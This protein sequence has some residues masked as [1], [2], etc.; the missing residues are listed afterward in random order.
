MKFCLRKRFA[1]PFWLGAFMGFCLFPVP[2]AEAIIAGG[3]WDIRMDVPGVV[4][5]DYHIEGRII[6]GLPGEGW[7]QPPVLVMHIDDLFPDF[8]YWIFPDLSDPAENVYFFRAYWSG[9]NYP[10][11]SETHLGL[12]FNLECHNLMIDIT[13]WWTVDGQPIGLTLLP[14]FEMNDNFG[15]QA[16]QY[17]RLWNQSGVEGEVVG[18]WFARLTPPEVVEL[19]GTPGKMFP[20]M[21]KGG[22]LDPEVQESGISWS[23]GVGVEP[24][25][26]LFPITPDDSQFFH[27]D[28]F[29][30][31]FTEL[32]V[33]P[34]PGT[35]GMD[36]GIDLKPAEF[37]VG[38]ELMRTIDQSGGEAFHWSW[39]IH[40]AHGLDFGDAPDPSYPTL[41]ASDG[42][43]HMAQGVLLGR[44]RDPEPDGQPTAFADGDDFL[45]GNDDEDGVTFSTSFVQGQPFAFRIDVVGSGYLSAWADWNADG[46]W[47]ATEQF[48]PGGWVT[49]GPVFGTM[50]VPPDAALGPTFMRYRISSAT[51]LRPEGF[52]PDGEV[53][54]YRIWV[55][56]DLADEYDWGDA[57]DDAAHFY[58]TLDANSGAHHLYN[59]DY[60][61]GN[62]ID[63]EKDG[64]PN[65]PA[66]GD[67]TTGPAADDEDG[68]VFGSAL[69]QGQTAK[70]DVTASNFGYV[71]AWLDYN[72]NGT[73]GDPWEHVFV[74]EPVGPG[75]NTLFL[76][77][78]AT[79]LPG[80]TYMR[81]RFSSEEGLPFYGGA[82]DGEVEDY[83]VGIEELPADL[84]DWGD[85]PDFEQIAGY[86]TLAM[87]NGARH[88][89]GSGLYLGKDIDPEADG[90]PTLAADGDD[91]NGIPDDED[92]VL[93]LSPLMQGQMAQIEV[94]ASQDGILNM[95]ID[96][97][98]NTSWGEL[99]DHALVNVSVLAG[100]N[101]LSFTV[102]PWARVGATYIRFRLSLEPGISY[103]GPAAYGEVEDYVRDIYP[104]PQ[105]G[106]D[107]G[108]AEDG[109]TAP[110]Y[111][112]L[113]WNNGAHHALGSGIHLGDH[114]DAEADGQPTNMADGDD[115][116]GIPDDEDGVQFLNISIKG[117]TTV[118]D[119]K[120]SQPGIL[121]VWADFN[122][123]KTW[124]EADEHILMDVPLNPG[125]NLL[126]YVVPD[127]AAF[128]RTT[129]RFRFSTMPG[130]TPEGLAVDGEVEDYLV[131]I[132]Q[133][134]P[135]V[136]HV[137]PANVVELNWN[138][139]GG[140]ASYSVYGSSG[141]DAFPPTWAIVG[142]SVPGSP[143]FDSAWMPRRFYLVVAE[144]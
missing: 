48:I 68:V 47:D 132:H 20:E 82:P 63:T 103:E 139:L 114:V 72:Q 102:P 118:I 81:V 105:E 127:D 135:T 75:L 38:V 60:Y 123:N 35:I 100:Y 11:D 85:A 142:P 15:G 141:L 128:G 121:N 122:Q 112:T 10:Y 144:P 51:G 32:S 27:I 96:L 8:S 108:D 29:F 19:F 57:P 67:D 31:V 119:V 41:L 17:L 3:N 9:Y 65:P 55:F 136:I 109:P 79:A 86:P 23:I 53:E 61:L 56:A 113:S 106:F 98:Q 138:P 33:D 78:P 13:G 43:R 18:L 6:S 140:A 59:P 62:E 37:L 52:A 2:H 116:T 39:E 45:D 40:E 115:V 104:A 134:V 92:G 25:G 76:N 99:A 42:A 95:W 137:S 131:K 77:V 21:R 5:N 24:T 107:W 1:L 110:G 28:S 80:A 14:G 87:H 125:S 94:F 22:R 73:W 50:P 101:L 4:A 64:Q 91:I 117:Y 133:L 30:D 44:L 124:A 16:E 130:L 83:L 12:F 129:F 46:T 89:L 69:A 97:D 66:D 26:E 7:S 84:F 93:F 90:Q 36:P 88:Q 49:T 70:V 120:A 54:D 111:P 74:D 126:N 58:R 143:W 71:N 34:E